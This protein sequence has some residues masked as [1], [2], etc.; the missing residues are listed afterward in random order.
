[1]NT[2]EEKMGYIFWY[3]VLACS[4]GSLITSLYHYIN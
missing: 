2:V 1:M 4:V 3:F